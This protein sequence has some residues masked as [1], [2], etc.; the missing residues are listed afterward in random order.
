MRSGIS[1]T[2]GS[3][4]ISSSRSSAAGT[5][6]GVS[7]S[8]PTCPSASGPASSRTPPPR[9]RSSIAWSA[10]PR[11][12]RSKGTATGGEWRRPSRN[13][14]DQR[15]PIDRR[16]PVQNSAVSHVRQ[17]QRPPPWI[18]PGHVATLAPYGRPRVALL[19]RPLTGGA[20]AGLGAG[21]GA[22]TAA[23]ERMSLPWEDAN[24]RE[25]YVRRRALQPAP[26]SP[27]RP[28]AR[29]KR[30]EGSGT[31]VPIATMS[32]PLWANTSP[33]ATIGVNAPS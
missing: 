22:A 29:R 32:P 5:N 23:G 26:A 24:Y 7:C 20:R 6:A 8:R 13:R 31:G 16:Q 30:V 33:S 4:P 3:P 21:A 2:M 15:R 27:A 11:S 25:C 19:G 12:S 28:V 18:E 1:P 17:H 10:T 9:R 14:H